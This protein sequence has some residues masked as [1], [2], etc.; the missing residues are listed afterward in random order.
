MERCNSIRD[1][2]VFR[3]C[4]SNGHDYTKGNDPLFKS[5]P[6]YHRILTTFRVVCKPNQALAID[7]SIVAWQSNS[8]YQVY[9]PEKNPS[10]IWCK[11]ENFVWRRKCILYKMVKFFIATIIVV[12]FFY[13]GFWTLEQLDLLE[14]RYS[15]QTWKKAQLG[16]RGGTLTISYWPLCCVNYKSTLMYRLFTW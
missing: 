5:N 6:M 9:S 8:S 2:E 3:C 12:P 7:E 13:H 11:S 1:K 4:Y 15:R 10:Q 16:N 14:K